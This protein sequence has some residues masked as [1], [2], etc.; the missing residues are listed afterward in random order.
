MTSDL[1]KLSDVRIV[2]RKPLSDE[3]LQKRLGGVPFV[4]GDTVHLSKV[5]YALKKLMIGVGWDIPGADTNGI[6]VDFSMFLLDKN[7]QTREDSDFVFYNN[8]TA[9]DGAVEHMGDN[10]TGAG[11]GDDERA[12]I[13][14]N[15]LPFDVQK[16]VFVI[17]I[18]DADMRD[19]NIGAIK[20]L[21]IRLVNAD[22]DVELLRF[23]IVDMAAHKRS[24]ALIAAELQRE[25]PTWLFTARGEMI[26]GSLGT[27]ATQY[28]ILVTG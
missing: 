15:A 20:N 19:Q 23:P 18:Y 4:A 7:D 2:E 16:I 5:D 12:L 14:L 8:L 3:E 25:G 17:S 10:R 22:T 11:D 26:E 28:G 21:F 13:D 1:D 27:I 24:S 6:D 9:Q